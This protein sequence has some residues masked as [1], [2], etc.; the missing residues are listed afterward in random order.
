[1]MAQRMNIFCILME[2]DKLLSS[3]DFTN[4]YSTDKV[5]FPYIPLILAV[6]NPLHFINMINKHEL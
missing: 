2:T 3:K 5:S 6:I 1:M 4:A